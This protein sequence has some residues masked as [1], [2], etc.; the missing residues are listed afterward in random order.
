M[1]L[2]LLRVASIPGRLDWENRH[3]KSHRTGIMG[4]DTGRCACAALVLLMLLLLLP[5]LICQQGL[6]YVPS[7]PTGGNQHAGTALFKH[8]NFQHMT[9][10]PLQ[11][12]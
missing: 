6:I 10:C 4:F 11:L 12:T 3:D 2:L 8:I 1:P 9:M 5:V 7:E